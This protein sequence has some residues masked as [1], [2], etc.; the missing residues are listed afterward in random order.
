MVALHLP[1][2]VLSTAVYSHY[3]RTRHNL[4]L[5]ALEEQE[6]RDAALRAQ[7]EARVQQE[8]VAGDGPA[9]K[10]LASKGSKGGSRK[11]VEPVEPAEKVRMSKSNVLLIGPTG[12][13]VAS[14]RRNRTTC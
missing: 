13:F 8:H 12:A 6:S 5:A 7:M 10:S 9:G 4:T 1:S 2:Q 11:V 14:C 3:I